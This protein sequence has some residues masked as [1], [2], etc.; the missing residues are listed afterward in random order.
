LFIEE[1]EE[2]NENNVDLFI[3]DW[4][5]YGDEGKYEQSFGN[6]L[7]ETFNPDSASL[8][9]DEVLGEVYNL[10]STATLL[11]LEE[12]KENLNNMLNIASNADKQGLESALRYLEELNVSAINS[13]EMGD[14]FG[15]EALYAPSNPYHQK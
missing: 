10:D 7:D 4:I 12:Y 8:G 6:Y 11:E 15:L 13:T 2:L 1:H 3:Q 9:L 5:K 14:M